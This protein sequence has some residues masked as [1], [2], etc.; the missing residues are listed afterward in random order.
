[1]GHVHYKIILNNILLLSPPISDI[2][3]HLQTTD[4]S[5]RLDKV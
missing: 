5:W 2:V 4:R 3:Q 1:M